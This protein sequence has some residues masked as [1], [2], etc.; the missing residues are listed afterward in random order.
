MTIIGII[1]AIIFAIL[2]SIYL[3]PFGGI[4]LLAVIFGLVLST[5]QRNKKMYEDIQRIKERLGIVDRNDFHMTNEEIEEELELQVH[6]ESEQ[7]HLEKINVEIEDELEAYLNKV[8]DKNKDM[9]ND[10]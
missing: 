9:D 8:K 7:K 4:V 6:S 5:H 3:G 10:K 2:I 1:T